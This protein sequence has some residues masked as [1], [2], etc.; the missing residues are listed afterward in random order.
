MIKVFTNTFHLWQS[1]SSSSPNVTPPGSRS[2]S[3][4]TRFFAVEKI[5]KEQQKTIEEQQKTVE[6][7]G[8]QM[9]LKSGW[10]VK[11]DTENMKIYKTQCSSKYTNHV[12]R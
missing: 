11:V 4:A 12:A 8:R 5:V 6:E 7:Q 9:Q 1:T 10:H 2:P 3:P